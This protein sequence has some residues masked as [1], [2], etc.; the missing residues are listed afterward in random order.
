MAYTDVKG[1]WPDQ[2]SKPQKGAPV[3]KF[4]AVRED[5]VPEEK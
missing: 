1:G 3:P 2:P 5:P 4:A